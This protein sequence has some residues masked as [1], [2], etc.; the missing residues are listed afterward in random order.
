[1][2]EFHDTGFDPYQHM[3]RLTAVVNELAQAHNN[4]AL[5]HQELQ[6]NLHQCQ[7]QLQ[8]LIRLTDL[9]PQ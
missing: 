2:S 7:L 9:N 1:M 8:Q 4:L 5:Q 6:K 3:M